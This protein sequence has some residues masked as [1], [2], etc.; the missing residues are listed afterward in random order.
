MGSFPSGALELLFLLLSSSP[1]SSLLPLLS[2]S[3]DSSLLPLLSSSM[4]V[5]RLL[6]GAMAS[7]GRRLDSL[8]R[9]KEEP[10]ERRGRSLFM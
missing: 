9:K 8:E 1:D 6:R 3:P 7:L 2:S 4:E 10:E 5:R